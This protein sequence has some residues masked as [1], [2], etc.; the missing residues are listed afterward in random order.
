[1]LS[2]LRPVFGADGRALRVSSGA[3]DERLDRAATA[4][5]EALS[6]VGVTGYLLTTTLSWTSLTRGSCLIW[7]TAASSLFSFI[8]WTKPTRVTT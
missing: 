7:T 2:W 1:M 4:I 5:R 8:F 3:W 6:P